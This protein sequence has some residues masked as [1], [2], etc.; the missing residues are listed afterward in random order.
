MTFFVTIIAFVLALGVLIV[1]H[2]FGHYLM[3]RW[4]GVKV[5]R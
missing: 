4:C 1:F 3:A 5:L 2:E